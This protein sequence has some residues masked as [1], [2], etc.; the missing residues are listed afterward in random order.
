MY[1]HVAA[2]KSKWGY[3]QTK[4][5]RSQQVHMHVTNG[6]QSV[7]KRGT[8]TL[9]TDDKCNTIELHTYYALAALVK[10]RMANWLGQLADWP[11]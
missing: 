7:C 5:N 11:G 3:T 6:S 8:D 4:T 1:N 2:T 10:T 9:E